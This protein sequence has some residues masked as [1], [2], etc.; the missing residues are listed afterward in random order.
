MLTRERLEQ[1]AGLAVI[2]AIVIGCF[3]V[4]RSFIS[5]ILWAAILCYATWPV[6][7]LMIRIFRGRRTLAAA[8]M[9]CILVVVVFVP[10]VVAGLT[11]TDMVRDVTDWLSTR[12]HEGL[13][14]PPDWLSRIPFFGDDIR[15]SWSDFYENTDRAVAALQPWLKASGLW[16]LKHTLDLAHGTFLMG[17]SLLLVFF[18]YR[19]GAGM[20]ESLRE[21]VRRISG[22]FAHNLM[23]VLGTTVR[24]VVYGMLGTAL[25]QGAV[26]WLGFVIAGVPAPL[27]LAVLTFLLALIPFGPPLVWIS[28]SVWLLM[29]G[30][31]GLS[32]F[33]VLYGLFIISG[34]DNFVRPYLISRGSQLPFALTMIGVLGG[35][36]AF[37]FIGL[38]L[39]PTLLAI[40]Y[41]I[42]KDFIQR[43]KARTEEQSI[44]SAGS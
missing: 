31:A 23:H 15:A 3:M 4:I 42:I 17:I 36:G 40:G 2:S 43:K 18:F 26:A 6:Y 37:G 10:V 14:P 20:V 39:G 7:E 35:L 32:V 34:I 21:G 13:P 1:I 24:S 11:L 33:M 28:V 41:S 16:L 19:D 12:R 27:L 30:Y 44:A 9:T 29:E 25:S 38:F 8:F 22:G 5:A